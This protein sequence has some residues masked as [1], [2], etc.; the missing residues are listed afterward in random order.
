MHGWSCRKERKSTSCQNTNETVK[1]REKPVSTWQG[2]SGRRRVEEGLSVLL[3]PVITFFVKFRDSRCSVGS[4]WGRELEWKATWT[5]MFEGLIGS[6]K[7]LW[8]TFHLSTW[9]DKEACLYFGYGCSHYSWDIK[10]S[11]LCFMQIWDQNLLFPCS[12]W[13][14]NWKIN[15]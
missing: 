11:I 15:I 4:E 1:N 14:P 10:I 5:R 12:L 9:R 3:G 13:N 7:I 2:C 8:E 6:D